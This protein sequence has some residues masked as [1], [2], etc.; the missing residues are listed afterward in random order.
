LGTSEK[1]RLI[2]GIRAAYSI[3][4]IDDVEDFVW[5]AIFAY[6]KNISLIDP[7]NHVRSKRLFDVIDD[8]QQIGWSIKTIQISKIRLPCTQEIVIQ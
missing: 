5:E 1:K 7:L 4:F 2:A 3:P 8:K 6:V